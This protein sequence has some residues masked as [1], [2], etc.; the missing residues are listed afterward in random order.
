MC[1]QEGGGAA[2][3]AGGGWWVGCGVVWCGVV[4]WLCV[5]RGGARRERGAGEGGEARGMCV[6][7]VWGWS[8]VVCGVWWWCGGRMT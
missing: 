3:A 4:W 6:F 1:E 8:V 2:A 5:W 7:V